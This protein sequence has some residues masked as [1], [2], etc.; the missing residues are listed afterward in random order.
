MRPEQ[1]ALQDRAGGGNL[2]RWP[3]SGERGLAQAAVSPAP[4]ECSRHL[5]EHLAADF[6]EALRPRLTTLDAH[7]A[8]AGYDSQA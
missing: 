8:A 3:G 4:A 2:R 7:E 1:A 5:S 6:G